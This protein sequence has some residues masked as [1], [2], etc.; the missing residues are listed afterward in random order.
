MAVHCGVCA[1]QIFSAAENEGSFPVAPDFK[2]WDKRDGKP[3]I[4]DTCES[5]APVLREAVATAA[6]KIAKRN[7]GRVDAL[8]QEVEAEKTRQEEARRKEDRDRK[9]FEEWRK[10]HV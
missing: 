6:N 5:C 10:R 4:S 2:G 8:A 3:R 7:R 1:K 9:E